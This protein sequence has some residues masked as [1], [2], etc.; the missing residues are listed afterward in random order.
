MN[1]PL[2]RTFATLTAAALIAVSSAGDAGA[3]SAPVPGGPG[4]SGVCATQA[5]AAQAS[6]TVKTL[7]SFG[8]CEVARRQS[9]LGQLTS[10]IGG[11]KSLSSAD[12]ARLKAVVA[13]ASAELTTLKT[14]LDS[15]V[16]VIALRATIVA[17]VNR[18]RAYVL[19]VPQV[20]LTIAADDVLSLQPHLSQLSAALAARIATA[21]AAG[22]DVAAA[23]ASLDAMN[24]AL[25]DAESLAAPWPAKLAP[26]TPAQYDS[27]VAG[28]TLNQARAALVSASVQLKTAVAAGRAVV[29]DLK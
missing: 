29:E 1:L 2:R 17:V 8:D 20:R 11:S 15:E 24:A 9:T 19:V 27:G 6:S 5:A 4:G 25:S 22:K 26:L 21:R 14:N 13:A 3:V 10:A 16:T 12:A 18:V 28:P 7:R 23:Q